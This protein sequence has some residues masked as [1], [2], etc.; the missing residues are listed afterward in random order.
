MREQAY[1]LRFSLLLPQKYLKTQHFVPISQFLLEEQ[2]DTKHL[3]YHSLLPSSDRPSVRASSST[4][5][6][7]TRSSWNRRRSRTRDWRTA[8]LSWSFC[9]R[10]RAQS[11]RRSQPPREPEQG[12]AQE[13]G[14]GPVEGPMPAKRHWARRLCCARTPLRLRQMST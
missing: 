13:Q 9:P 4:A 1:H 11:P 12:L 14:L 6:R 3:A 5:P 10:M 7:S 8:A 2:S